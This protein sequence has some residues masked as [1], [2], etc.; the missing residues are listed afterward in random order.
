MTKITDGRIADEAKVSGMIE[1]NSVRVVFILTDA[2]AASAAAGVVGVRP[3]VL[4]SVAVQRA[5]VIASCAS[6]AA[7]STNAA[8]TAATASASDASP[9]GVSHT[10]G[11]SRSRD[12][13]DNDIIIVVEIDPYAER[14]SRN[15]AHAVLAQRNGNHSINVS[16]QDR[17]SH[18]DGHTSN[19]R[20][21]Q[22]LDK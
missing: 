7:A 6:S 21:Y 13:A 8:G 17:H 20:R 5:K 15:S 18:A 12:N 1:R 22:H 10:T 19:R 11:T 2:Y 14:R 9:D 16:Q 3:A 4:V